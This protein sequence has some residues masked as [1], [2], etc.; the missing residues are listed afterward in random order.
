MPKFDGT[1]PRG[2]GPMTGRGLGIMRGVGRPRA[3]RRVNFDP[4]VKYFKPQGIPLVDLEEIELSLEEMEALRLK[5]LEGL[6]QTE[7]AEKVHTSQSTFQRLLASAYRKI[8]EALVEGKAI[9]I[10]N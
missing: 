10:N 5:N 2:Q 9:K 6:G 7:A 4:R 8:A 3:C 1:G